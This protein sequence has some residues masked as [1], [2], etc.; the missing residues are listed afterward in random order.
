MYNSK[1]ITVRLV[2][3]GDRYLLC[4]MN[5]DFKNPDEGGSYA[6]TTTEFSIPKYIYDSLYLLNW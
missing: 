5:I 2:N 3:D 1:E 4:W 6:V